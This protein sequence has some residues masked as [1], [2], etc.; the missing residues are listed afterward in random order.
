MPLNIISNFAAHVAQRNLAT[1]DA[2][3]TSSL[4]KLSSG[5]RV[6]SAKDDASSLAIGARL[7]AEVAGLKQASVNAGQAISMLQIADGAMAKVNDILIRMKSLA[8]QAGS[9][10]LSGTDRSMLDTEY[11][12]LRSE[13]DRIAND[14]DFA[15][16]RLVNGD[17]QILTYAAPNF[18]PD[19]GIRDITFHGDF[20]AYT[21]AQISYD[22]TVGAFSVVAGSETYSGAMSPDSHD[23]TWMAEATVVTLSSTS[24]TNKIFIQV[25]ASFWM[26]FAHAAGFLDFA[27][28]NTRDFTFKVGTGALDPSADEITISLN[29]LS[30]DALAIATGDLTTETNAASSTIAISSAIDSLQTFRAE[31]GGDL[32]RLEFAE[33]NIAT[34]SENVEAARSQLLDLDIASE[35]SKFVSRQILLQ[36]GASMLAQANKLPSN[37]LQLLR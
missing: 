5:R 34:T 27:T 3:A 6:V 30:T 21:N 16:T 26:G 2:A 4:S 12:T 23:G 7:N 35:M 18:Q 32:N 20:D 14:T 9:G 15:G 22:H 24:S 36:S 10:Q 8:V 1:S 31:I 25:D 29:N 37:L 28:N 19:D 13:V 11:Q 17:F 33:A